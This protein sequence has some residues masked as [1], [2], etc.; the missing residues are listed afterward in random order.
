MKPEQLLPLHHHQLQSYTTLRRFAHQAISTGTR[1]SMLLHL[2]KKTIWS[3]CWSSSRTTRV[4]RELT[5]HV[6]LRKEVAYRSRGR[7]YHSRSS[8]C[9]RR[10]PARTLDSLSPTFA[11]NSPT[12]T[13]GMISRRIGAWTSGMAVHRENV[14]LVTVLL[15]LPN[16]Y[17]RDL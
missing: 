12:T 5:R 16:H 15:M 9:N 6:V 13:P 2:K 7:Y 11:L 17:G 4:R 1:R 14:S 10:L 3:K 8:L